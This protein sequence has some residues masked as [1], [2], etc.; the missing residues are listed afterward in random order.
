MRWTASDLLSSCAAGDFDFR[1]QVRR[2]GTVLLYPVLETTI[3]LMEIVRNRVS[4]LAIH[5]SSS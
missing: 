2:E 5:P 1:Y 4:K 3:V